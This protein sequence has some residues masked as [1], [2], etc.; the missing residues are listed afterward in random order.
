MKGI[1]G[2]TKKL[3]VTDMKKGNQRDLPYGITPKLSAQPGYVTVRT[4][5]F[6]CMIFWFSFRLWSFR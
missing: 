4:A 2:T 3:I 5:A 6:I 1:C